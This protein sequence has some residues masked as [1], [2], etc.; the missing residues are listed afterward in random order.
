[1]THRREP[2]VAGLFYPLDAEELRYELDRFLSLAPDSPLTPKAMIVPHAGYAYSGAIAASAYAQLAK[3]AP[4][5]TQVALFGPSHR[6]PL[7]GL[8]ICNAE[9]FLTPLGPV[10][11][12]LARCQQ[13]MQFPQVS[14]MDEAHAQEHSLEVQLPFLQ[15]VLKDFKLIPIV[16]GDASAEQVCEVMEYLWQQP[17]M[18][19]IV[20]SDLSHY[21]DYHTAQQLDQQTTDA[22]E[23]LRPDQIGY[24]QACGRNP[25]NGLLLLAQHQHLQASTLDLRNSGDTSGARDRVVGYGAY[26]FH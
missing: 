7:R 9:Q 1:M 18:L 26:V 22:I 25:V 24:E 16:V 10:G 5:I 19:I 8:A 17:G 21:H 11:V 14:I 15:T 3:I 13:L 23:H 4:Q 12:D 2:A 6:V 20:S